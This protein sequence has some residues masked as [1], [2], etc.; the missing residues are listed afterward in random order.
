MSFQKG[1]D[2]LDSTFSVW[3]DQG[4]NKIPYTETSHFISNQ[5][6]QNKSKLKN[7]GHELNYGELESY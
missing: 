3:L 7:D 1:I 6:C 4:L 2:D 5:I